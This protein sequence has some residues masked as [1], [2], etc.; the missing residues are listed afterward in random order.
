MIYRDQKKRYPWWVKT[1]DEITTET[2]DSRSSKP[3][4]HRIAHTI[5][6]ESDKNP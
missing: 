3:D 4:F 2:D 1:V 5:L 6:F